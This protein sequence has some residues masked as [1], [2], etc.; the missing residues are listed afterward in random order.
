MIAAAARRRA[1]HMRCEKK[2][3]K[4]RN[5]Y[6]AETCLSLGNASQNVK[7]PGAPAG[8]RNAFKHGWHSAKRLALRRRCKALV[9]DTHLL[10]AAMKALYPR[11]RS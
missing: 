5:N 2:G 4:T 1:R 9:R 11:V 10:I 7:Q 6:R 3:G 8:N